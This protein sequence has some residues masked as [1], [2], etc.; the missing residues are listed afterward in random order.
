MQLKR[1][2]DLCSRLLELGART[3]VDRALEKLW[4][5][6]SVFHARSKDRTV[7][8]PSRL[9]AF[10]QEP[11]LDIAAGRF[12]ARSLL[13]AALFHHRVLQYLQSYLL[14][15]SGFHPKGIRFL[16]LLRVRRAFLLH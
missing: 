15:T 5:V 16:R 8:G 3:S 9:F 4:T 1:M 10:T 6:M 14:K 2:P 12:R 13:D 7:F 11:V